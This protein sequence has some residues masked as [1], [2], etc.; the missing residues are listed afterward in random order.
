MWPVSKYKYFG[1]EII[2]HY[3]E[4]QRDPR[5]SAGA[6]TTVSPHA[7]CGLP[8]HSRSGYFVLWRIFLEL[9]GSSMTW[10]V[11]VHLISVRILPYTDSPQ[12]SQVG[13]PGGYASFA[14]DG[15][16]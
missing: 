13:R 9:F 6:R 10:Y 12:S 8:D 3:D 11:T 14:T 1:E 5:N 4:Y 7:R 16:T 2:V 15:T